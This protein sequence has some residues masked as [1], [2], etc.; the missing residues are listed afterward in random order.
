MELR[1]RELGLFGTKLHH[2]KREGPP[3]DHSFAHLSRGRLVSHQSLAEGH[4]ELR[5]GLLIV[6][7]I[8]IRITEIRIRLGI[9]TLGRALP[10]SR[11][12]PVGPTERRVVPRRTRFQLSLSGICF[13]IARRREDLLDQPF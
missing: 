5:G 1:R 7:A 13:V 3:H 12:P 11:R 9:S 2:K 4:T 10:R 6:I 8:S